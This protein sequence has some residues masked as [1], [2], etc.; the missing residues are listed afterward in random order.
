ME[1][2]GPELD[3][4]HLQGVAP[5]HSTPAYSNNFEKRDKSKDGARSV[6][7]AR[8]EMSEL[9]A[10]WQCVQ[11]ARRY[12]YDTKGL[13][14]PTNV[15][16]AHHIF[17][18]PWIL[19][20]RTG[21]KVPMKSV[22]NGSTTAPTAGSL[23]I[24]SAHL[25]NFPGHVGAIV[26]V[27]PK[28]DKVYVACQNRHSKKWDG[29]YSVV[30]DVVYD[31]KKGTWTLVDKEEPVLGWVTFPESPDLPM[32]DGHRPPVSP[33]VADRENFVT[34]RPLPVGFDSKKLPLYD[35]GWFQVKLWGHTLLG[36]HP[37]L[38]PLGPVVFPFFFIFSL[39]KFLVVYPLMHK[40]G[41]V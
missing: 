29:D 14:L 19:D 3:L 41:F 27:S 26:R 25:G 40:L 36:F 12:M 23:I 35:E 15:T 11:F 39:V 2:A 1:P 17:Y 8:F 37:Q 30:H 6:N 5:P 13:W 38:Y 34:Q 28:I 9:G 22:L 32:P 16:I 20:A 24:Y 4:D 10:F 31:E 21:K 18:L 33:V 7:G